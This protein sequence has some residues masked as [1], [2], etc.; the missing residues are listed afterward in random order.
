MFGGKFIYRAPQ[1]HICRL[2]GQTLFSDPNPGDI[3]QCKCGR[4]YVCKGPE[5]PTLHIGWKE[6]IDDVEETQLQ[7]PEDG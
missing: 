4:K 7:T 5:W 6:I 3:W 2:P 1:P